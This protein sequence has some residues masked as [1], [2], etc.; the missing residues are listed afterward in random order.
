MSLLHQC[1]VFINSLI[2]Y[3]CTEQLLIAFIKILK[4]FKKLSVIYKKYQI[5]LIEL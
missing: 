3:I 4:R 1:D 2:K 5:I